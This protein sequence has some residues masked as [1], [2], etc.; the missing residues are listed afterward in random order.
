MTN[1]YPDVVEAAI[2]TA[3]NVPEYA[4]DAVDGMRLVQTIGMISKERVRSYVWR[5]PSP[6][7]RTGLRSG[8]ASDW[9]PVRGC[10]GLGRGRWFGEA[11]KGTLEVT[12]TSQGPGLGEPRSLLSFLQS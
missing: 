10:L 1:L 8:G 6:G 5:G 11:Q 2:V 4:A 3:L 7:P 9:A 12:V